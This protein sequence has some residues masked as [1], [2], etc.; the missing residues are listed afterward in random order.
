MRRA[1]L[2]TSIAGMRFSAAM[3]RILVPSKFT[4]YVVLLLA[5]LLFHILLQLRSQL[6]IALADYGSHVR[7]SVI[8]GPF[9]G[10]CATGITVTRIVKQHA[11]RVTGS[12]S[13]YDIE[14]WACTMIE[15]LV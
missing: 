13:D 9:V 5:T 7:R 10:A 2:D 11:I 14:V 6:R 12:L 8:V 1:K 3:L 15:M 4:I